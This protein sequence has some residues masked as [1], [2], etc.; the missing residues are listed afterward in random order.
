MTDD[1]NWETLRTLASEA[2][3]GDEFHDFEERLPNVVT[4]AIV[5]NTGTVERYHSDPVFHA[6][7]HTLVNLVLVA[8]MGIKPRR[9]PNETTTLD[10][11]KLTEVFQEEFDA[12]RA[13]GRPLTQAE[14]EHQIHGLD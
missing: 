3:I 13:T 11:G 8:I 6:Q 7:V 5:L 12:S 14:R 10:M 9:A 2:G 4:S 1:I